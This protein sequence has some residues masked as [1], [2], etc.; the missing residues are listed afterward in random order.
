MVHDP[1][2]WGTRV[3]RRRGGVYDM[4]GDM[5]IIG[6]S[7][8]ER[9]EKEYFGT[10]RREGRLKHFASLCDSGDGRDDTLLAH[11]MS[12]LFLSSPLEGLV[13]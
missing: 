8:F 2:V 9:T 6:N 12:H 10:K 7:P 3:K 13:F 1:R 4:D 5:G 11:M